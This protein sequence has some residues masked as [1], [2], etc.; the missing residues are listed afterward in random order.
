MEAKM[1]NKTLELSEVTG[2][3]CAPLGFRASGVHCGIRKSQSKKDL[4]LIIADVK[5]SAAAVYTQNKVC[6]APITVTRE[7][8]SGGH[9]RAVIVNSGNANT[10]NANGIDI[11]RAMCSLVEG[12][13]GVPAGEVIIASTGVIGEPLNIEPIRSGMGAL[14]AGLSH[15]GQAAAEAIMT[16]DT[17]AKQ[18]AVEFQL[19]DKTCRIGAMAKGSGM[20][21]PNMATLLGFITTDAAVEPDALNALLHEAVED[22]FNM[23]SID[24]DTSTNDMVSIMASG[25][26]GNEPITMSDSGE[27]A[28][29]LK[30][31]KHVCVALARMIA[32]DGEGATKLI[33]CHVANAPDKHTARAVAKSVINSSL[34]K[35]AMF[36]ADANWGRILCAIGYAPAE[37][38]IGAINVSLS[39]S[40]GSIK[41]CENGS[42]TGFDE[43]TAKQILL[44]GEVTIEIDMA[45][46][47]GE[48]T[49]WG[50]DLTY[51][52]VKINGSYRT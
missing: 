44:Q 37:F 40:A 12:A 17:A 8:I 45:Q 49:A 2:G 9:A 27:R 34:I 31:L 38:E 10:C 15:D 28:A 18:D 42:G 30:A 11:A 16:T 24:G 1:K 25:L 48:A 52:Y 29:F 6:G 20:I 23:V 33:T 14:V 43:K 7:N 50:C 35:A 22:S 51:D 32:K 36:A 5:C 4:A 46:G 39:S 41:V 21:M 26:I 47:D 19:G 3:V 13:A